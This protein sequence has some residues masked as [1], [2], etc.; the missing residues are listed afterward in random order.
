MLERESENV[1]WRLDL[2]YVMRVGHMLIN[3]LRKMFHDILENQLWVPKILQK[4]EKFY[5]FLDLIKIVKKT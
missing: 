3:L 5:N 4:N 2:S 1:K